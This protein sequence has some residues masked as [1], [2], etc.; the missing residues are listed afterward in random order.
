MASIVASP[1]P[2]LLTD[3]GIAVL[4]FA[5]DA[6]AADVRVALIV[7]TDVRGGAARRPGS[8]LA[9]RS[10]GRYCGLISGG[11]V[12]AAA[13]AEAL[14]AIAAGEDRSISYGSGSP[15]MDI[16]L[17]CGGGITARIHVL[18]SSRA[19]AAALSMLDARVPTGLRCDLASQSL[20]CD[21]G[22][23]RTGWRESRFEVALRPRTRLVVCGRSLEAESTATL[24]RTIG[25]DVQVWDATTAAP[26]QLIDEDTAVVLLLHDPERELVALQAALAA[27]P[28]Y[29]GALGSSRTHQ[30]RAR[31]LADL[32]C[33]DA[34]IGRIKA[35]IGIFP[36]ARDAHSLALSVLADVAAIRTATIDAQRVAQ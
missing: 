23:R 9:V 6:V 12:E 4:R 31:A 35:P 7:L 16:V 27:N 13:A 2:G 21:P 26:S 24:A 14:D 10:D 36:K 34:A 15:Y 3:D 5:A 33:S 20:A 25:Y 28:F 17:P 30:R 22:I 18:R 32:G 29:V 19:P 1:Q 8:L 11:C